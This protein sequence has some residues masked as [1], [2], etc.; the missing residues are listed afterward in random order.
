MGP[1]R[2]LRR[3][4]TKGQISD[5]FSPDG[6]SRMRQSSCK[7]LI[8]A[9]PIKSAPTINDFN[10]SVCWNTQ[11]WWGSCLIC[12]GWKKKRK[13]KKKAADCNAAV[14]WVMLIIYGNRHVC[15]P[16]DSFGPCAHTHILA[17][18]HTHTHTHT[19]RLHPRHKPQSIHPCAR[20]MN[21]LQH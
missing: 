3:S 1:R 9:C 14:K 19:H 8:K 6:N 20:M 4:Q 12:S 15:A 11:V 5:T 17:H 10:R 13:E 21:K 2:A 7:T 18:T 16:S